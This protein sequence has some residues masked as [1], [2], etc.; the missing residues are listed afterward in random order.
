[1]NVFG[2]L[3]IDHITSRSYGRATSKNDMLAIDSQDGVAFHF[4]FLERPNVI[5]PDSIMVT[6]GLYLYTETDTVQVEEMLY[7]A[8]TDP[9][10]LIRE[11]Q[12]EVANGSSLTL[13]YG[14][15]HLFRSSP[16]VA[17]KSLPPM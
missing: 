17:V 7:V 13:A 15:P 1:M 9:D 16:H 4:F 6:Y 14:G 12:M 5:L 8:S 3:S 2:S 11:S 10:N